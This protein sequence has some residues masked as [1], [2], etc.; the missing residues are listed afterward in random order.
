MSHTET[1]ILFDRGVLKKVDA[2]DFFGI[3]LWLLVAM[4]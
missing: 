2:C 4:W 3:L 1:D